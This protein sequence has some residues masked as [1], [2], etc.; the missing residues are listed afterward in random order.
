M[1]AHNCDQECPCGHWKPGTANRY[2]VV[3]PTRGKVTLDVIDQ[4]YPDL[5]DYSDYEMED[6]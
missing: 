6:D 1:R 3:Q 2:R 4:T 5:D